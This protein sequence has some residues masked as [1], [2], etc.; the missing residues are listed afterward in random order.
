MADPITAKPGVQDRMEQYYASARAAGYSQ[1]EIASHLGQRINA[2]RTEALSHG[3]TEQQIDQHLGFSDPR[4]VLHDLATHA[5]ENLTAQPETQANA[6]SDPYHAFIAGLQASSGGFLVRG[7][8]PDTVLA[9]HAGTFSRL[10]REAGEVV[11]DLPAMGAG[12]FGGGLLGAGGGGAAG[13]T[14]GAAV[15]VAGETGVSEVAG[16]GVGAVG[17]AVVAGGAGMNALPTF[18]KQA[19]VRG[20][21][22]HMWKDPEDFARQTAGILWNTSKAGAVGAATSLVGGKVGIALAKSGEAI[23]PFAKLGIKSAAELTTMVTASSALE[24]KLPTREDFLDGA[25][26]LAAFHIAGAGAG[27]LL[28]SKTVTNARDNLHED[29]VQNNGNPVQTATDATTDPLKRTKF[30]NTPE[31]KAHPI[32]ATAD[33]PHG[34]FV[35]QHVPSSFDEDVAF[36]MDK[37]EGGGRLNTDTGGVTKWGISAKAHPDLDIKNLSRED[38]QRVYHEEY[39]K[40]I[41]ADAITDPALRRAAFDS[42]VNEG[43]SSTKQWLRESGGD[44]QTFLGLR[45]QRYVNLLDK[46]PEKYG[47]YEATWDARMKRLGAEMGVRDMAS[48]GDQDVMWGSN[49]RERLMAAKRALTTSNGNDQA[50]YEVADRATDALGLPRIERRSMPQEKVETTQ[51]TASPAGAATITPEEATARFGDTPEARLMASKRALSSLHAA[52]K[53]GSPE[54]ME[55]EEVFTKA[56]EAIHSSHGMPPGGP[57]P[58]PPAERAEPPEGPEGASERIRAMMGDFDE[59]KPKASAWERIKDSAESMYREIFNPEHPVW[60]LTDAALGKGELPDLENPRI[61]ARMAELAPSLG[62]YMIERGMVDTEGNATGKSLKDV[63]GDL[64]GK[65]LEDFL[66][67][68]RARWGQDQIRQG[69]ETPNT[70]ADY[71]KVVADGR[72]MHEGRYNDLVEWR[73][74][75]LKYLRDSGLISDKAYQTSL[76]EGSGIPGYRLLEEATGGA[77]GPGKGRTAYNPLKRSTGSDL[78][79][80]GILENLLKEAFQRTELGRRNLMN[81]SIAD[82]AEDLGLGRKVP[83]SKLVKINVTDAEL[84]KAMDEEGGLGTDGE[85]LDVY[86]RLGANLKDNQV[87]VFRDGKMEVWEFDDPEIAKYVRGFDKT[88]LNTL[89]RIVATVTRFQRSSIVHSPDFPV[90]NLLYDTSWQFIKNPG[91]RNTLA[92]NIMGLRGLFTDPEGFDAWMRSGGAEGVFGHFAKDDYI[93]DVL[94][95][96]G[97]PAFTD[98]AWNKIRT[99]WDGLRAWGQM[100]SMAPRFGRF[101]QGQKEGESLQA[102]GAASTDAAF[103]RAGYGSSWA[104][105]INSVIPFFTAHLNSLEQTIRGQLGVGKT[106]EGQDFNGKQFAM[107]AAALITMP[108]LASWFFNKDKEWYKAAPDWQKDNGMLFHVGPDDG[109]HTLFLAYPPLVS[110]IYGGMPRRMAEAFLHDN[111]HAADGMGGSFGMSLLPP[112]LLTG[113]G[114]MSPI[115]EHIANHSFFK[116]RPLVPDDVKRNAMAPE[117]FTMYSSDT[118]KV[119]SKFVNDTPLLKNLKLSPP[120]IDNYLQGWGGTLGRDA[121]RTAEMAYHSVAGDRPTP[122]LEDWPLLSSWLARYPSGSAQP[123]QDFRT[124]MDDFNAVH[125]SLVKL[126]ENHDLAR[127]QKLAQENPTAAIAH[128]YKLREEEPNL[129]QYASILD[130]AGQAGDR[131]VA[132]DVMLANK[133]VAG[134]SKFVSWIN[135]N[136]KFTPTDKRQLID[137]AYGIQQVVAERGNAQLDA[138]EKGKKI[139]RLQLPPETAPLINMV[140]GG[141]RPP[142]PATHVGEAPVG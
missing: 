124:R 140:K 14:A 5:Q 134:L 89:G 84:M 38:A 92:A 100:L 88:S 17:G 8:M 32:A 64:K 11:G 67:Y 22:T 13:A 98:G 127:F 113:I 59:A 24:G 80:A 122:H 75:T 10:A 87:P 12:A 95:N 138:M 68:A 112:G 81:Q 85:G 128:A 34:Q 1:D 109:G 33:T 56:R 111:P 123:T 6:V 126:I 131:Q 46:Q 41:N 117:Q 108:V 119:L 57:P 106:I 86:R 21:Q 72:G 51:A 120:V 25:A 30:L 69:K 137:Q 35:L 104:R 15:P 58:E 115:I 65:D 96:G 121:I 129:Q 16:G 27:K 66:I 90:R 133:A 142:M 114:V 29:W 28:P 36:V 132:Q 99:P 136:P 48:Y 20:L 61:Q 47:K 76:A 101:L 39:W 71:E 116:D 37:Q 79:T 18:I 118:A 40:P 52:G 70:A 97:D 139:G 135:A 55:A 49:A 62:R 73:N 3:Y 7:K 26:L 42:A 53:E 60:K 50:A 78:R 54:W 77:G 82:V 141:P 102:A 83:A 23:N 91:F 63:V 105:N 130:Q 31:P 43:V 103:H 4:P 74:G 9:Q 110:F 107:K 44:L 93:K 125:G 2:Y 19:Y 94:N 45:A